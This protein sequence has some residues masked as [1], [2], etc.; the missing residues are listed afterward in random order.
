MDIRYLSI[1]TISLPL[2]DQCLHN[3]PI[4]HLLVYPP[5]ISLDT[6]AAVRLGGTRQGGG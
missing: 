5:L 2:L 1:T 6:A 3:A 4:A